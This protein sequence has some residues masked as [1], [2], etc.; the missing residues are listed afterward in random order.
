MVP[1]AQT[2]AT[3]G[4]P[5]VK[6]PVLSKTTAVMLPAFSNATPSRIKMP[7]WAATLEAAMM[8]AGVAKPIAQGQ[9]TI[10]TAA[11]IIKPDANAVSGGWAAQ[12]NCASQWCACCAD[13][14]ASPHH[15]PAAKATVTTS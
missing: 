15:S 12:R 11:A 3:E 5:I 13:E 14:G 10:N 8:A 9:A 4:F 1:G 7:L 2:L 6:V